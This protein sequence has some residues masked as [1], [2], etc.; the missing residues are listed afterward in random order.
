MLHCQIATTADLALLR[1]SVSRPNEAIVEY[2][3]LQIPYETA[4]GRELRTR[5]GSLKSLAKVFTYAREATSELGEWCADQVW[6]FAMAEKEAVRFE[7]RIEK[8]FTKKHETTSVEMLDDEIGR[9]HEAQKFVSDWKFVE[10]MER[11]NGIS[12][13]V[14][15]LRQYL[16]LIFERPTDARCII[17]VDRRYTARLLKELFARF[18]SPHLRSGLLVGARNG[19]PGDAQ[20]SVRQQILTLNQFR[21][22]VL[23]CLV[24]LLEPGVSQYAKL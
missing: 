7:R 2:A 14:L 10:P 4:L 8:A 18:G 13:K 5:Y 3:G 1:T 11:P 9:L 16:D 24:M 21:K 6:S 22:G 17:F 20:L 15:V 19:D 23:N 12:S